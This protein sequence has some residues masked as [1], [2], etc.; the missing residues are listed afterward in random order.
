MDILIK[1]V[2]IAKNPKG[3]NIKAKNSIG[4]YFVG[5]DAE[6]LTHFPKW[7]EFREAK[8]KEF[9]NESQSD[10]FSESHIKNCNICKAYKEKVKDKQREMLIAREEEF[11][12]TS[13]L[14]N[15]LEVVNFHLIGGTE[16]G[17]NSSGDYSGEY[18]KKEDIDKLF[19]KNS[20]VSDKSNYWYNK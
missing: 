10:N 5:N 7:E 16:Y 11:I 18:Y 4:Y 13:P 6:G 19:S 2:E 14:H 15:F 8:C 9:V 1:N 20:E 12:R 17:C 3:Y